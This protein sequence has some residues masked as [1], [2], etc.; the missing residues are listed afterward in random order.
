MMKTCGRMV[1][2]KYLR[3]WSLVTPGRRPKPGLPSIVK[4]AARSANTAPCPT[5]Y[6]AA[7]PFANSGSTPVSS[8]WIGAQW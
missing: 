1:K 5:K 8:G 3:S 6:W 7:K 2:A 4:P